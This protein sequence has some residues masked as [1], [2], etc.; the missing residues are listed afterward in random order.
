MLIH[1]HFKC[2]SVTKIYRYTNLKNK[3]TICCFLHLSV[4][5]VCKKSGV[6]AAALIYGMINIF[7]IEIDV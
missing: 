4:K 6:G 7:Y 5:G 3:Q 2:L 1:Y